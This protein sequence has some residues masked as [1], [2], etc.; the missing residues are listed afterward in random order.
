MKKVYKFKFSPL[1]YILSVIINILFLSVIVIDALKIAGVGNFNTAYLGLDVGAIMIS[2]IMMVIVGIF[3]FGSSYTLT[4]EYLRYNLGFFAYKIEYKNIFLIR[5]EKS[6]HT[7]V[8]NYQ[9]IK[10]DKDGNETSGITGL[11]ININDK[12]KDAFV[13]D[14]RSKNSRVLYEVIDKNLGDN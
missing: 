7:L 8:L 11:V 1:I 13:E 12:K 5:E 10:K 2:I 9:L 3:I 4:D 14:I 6:T